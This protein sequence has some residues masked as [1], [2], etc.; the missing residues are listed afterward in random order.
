MLKDGAP[1]GSEPEL[2]DGKPLPTPSE[3]KAFLDD[4]IIGQHRAKKSAG[5]G[6]IQPLQNACTS[7][8]K[9]LTTALKSSKATS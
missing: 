8:S 9:K 7:T 3:I 5:G 4:Y 1:A 2:F 6:G